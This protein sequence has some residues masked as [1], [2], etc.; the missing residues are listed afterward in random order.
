MNTLRSNNR[1]K[2]IS[3]QC[4]F[5][6]LKNSWISSNFLKAMMSRSSC[7]AAQMVYCFN[8]QHSMRFTQTQC[9][10]CTPKN[11]EHCDYAL[12]KRRWLTLCGS[13]N[14]NI[15]TCRHYRLLMCRFTTLPGLLT[16]EELFSF[17]FGLPFH[18]LLRQRSVS[19]GL[20]PAGVRWTFPFHSVSKF[21]V[22][23]FCFERSCSRLFSGLPPYW[24]FVFCLSPCAH[25]YFPRFQL[26]VFV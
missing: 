9:A 14:A 17:P 7:R 3:L 20:V 11:N 13:L 19:S 1:N 4:S 21:T 26:S 15:V 12:F 8:T 5:F 6:Q 18:F 22:F 23:L 2:A 25:A 16:T 24:M 10:P